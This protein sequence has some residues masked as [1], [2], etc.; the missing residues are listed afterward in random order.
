M[1]CVYIH[2]I[3]DAEAQ[4]GGVC[5]GCVAMRPFHTKAQVFINTKTDQILLAAAPAVLSPWL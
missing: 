4:A 1:F 3:G 5:A 2:I